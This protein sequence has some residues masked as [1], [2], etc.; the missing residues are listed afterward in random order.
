MESGP[1]AEV[2]AR[3]AHP[4]T[5]GLMNS[6]PRAEMKHE[7]L[8]TI[9]GAPPVLTAMPSGCAFHPRCARRQPVCSQDRPGLQGVA[10]ERQSACHFAAEVLGA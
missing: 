6:V 3:P 1:T 5:I 2:V 8:R 7:K 4:Y 9:E 10:P